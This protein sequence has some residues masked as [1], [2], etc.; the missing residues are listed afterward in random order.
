M[1]L[2]TPSLGE[3]IKETYSSALP[4]FGNGMSDVFG[5]KILAETQL[6]EE[7]YER[8]NVLVSLMPPGSEIT[9]D[10]VKQAGERFS[11]KKELCERLAKNEKLCHA[12]EIRRHAITPIFLFVQNMNAL[13]THLRLAF[14]DNIG[15][16]LQFV[17]SLEAEFKTL[18]REEINAELKKWPPTGETLKSFVFSSQVPVEITMNIAKIDQH[19]S[20][21]PASTAEL[22]PALPTSHVGDA[23]DVDILRWL[24]QESYEREKLASYFLRISGLA[25]RGGSQAP[26]FLMIP[27]FVDQLLRKHVAVL[28]CRNMVASLFQVSETNEIIQAVTDRS[29][30]RFN[31]AAELA[32]TLGLEFSSEFKFYESKWKPYTLRSGAFGTADKYMGGLNSADLWLVQWAGAKTISEFPK[33]LLD[34]IPA[35]EIQK[36]IQLLCRKA[37]TGPL[38]DDEDYFIQEWNQETFV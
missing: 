28:N 31:C 21:L 30:D 33:H 11:K 1:D 20:T 7:D 38:S 8:I 19:L 18:P 26:T 14:K 37:E 17:D 36:R 4:G 29:T 15:D 22:L 32:A 34:E 27:H 35:K 13:R 25:L 23:Q 12:A 3:I 16:M 6:S 5:R 9:P 10:L 24:L 2:E